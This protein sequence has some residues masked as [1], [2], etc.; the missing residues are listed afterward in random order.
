MLEMKPEVRDRVM[1][2]DK[3]LVAALYNATY[4]QVITG[5]SLYSETLQLRQHTNAILAKF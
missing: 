1:S 2:H 3:P 5:N 4:N